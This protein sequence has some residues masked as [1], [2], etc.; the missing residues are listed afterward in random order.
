MVEL[1][2]EGGVFAQ[3]AVGEQGG[4]VH[5]DGTGVL[6][7]ANTSFE[8]VTVGYSIEPVCLTL[9]MIMT[10]G[11]GW[12]DAELFVFRKEDYK[13]PLAVYDCPRT[14]NFDNSYPR[15]C[16]GQ[17][18]HQGTDPAFCDIAGTDLPTIGC[19]CSGC[20]CAGFEPPSH[21]H[22]HR[23][24]LADGFSTTEQVCFERGH[25]QGE[26]V[27]L[28]TEDRYYSNVQWTLGSHV[29]DGEANDLRHLDF[30]TLESK[31]GCETP[32]EEQIFFFSILF[33]CHGT[34]ERKLR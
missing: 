17:E 11:G 22:L 15:S 2:I 13:G 16:D 19:D 4:A 1:I 34:N 30:T 31:E 3:C 33:T 24:T 5:V 28:V 12:D 18:Y 10:S 26:Y 23:T 6:R 27:I 7:V 25:G 14:C 9:T 29:V 20:V 32:G 8:D 21:T